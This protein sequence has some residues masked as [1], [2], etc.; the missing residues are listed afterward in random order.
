MSHTH[1][2]I[3]TLTRAR[4]GLLVSCVDHNTGKRLWG[5][6]PQIEDLKITASK[7]NNVE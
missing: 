5:F 2:L 3:P 4:L 6:K 7:Q 1:P